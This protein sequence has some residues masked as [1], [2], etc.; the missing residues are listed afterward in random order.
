MC[1]FATLTMS[2]EM[3]F[4]KPKLVHLFAWLGS[5]IVPKNALIFFERKTVLQNKQVLRKKELPQFQ[6][7]IIETCKI[8]WF[9]NS[10]Q[11]DII[12]EMEDEFFPK[13]LSLMCNLT[14]NPHIY[15]LHGNSFCKRHIL[16]TIE[17]TNLF[18]KPN[19]TILLIQKLTHHH[20]VKKRVL[21]KW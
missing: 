11:F 7:L 20:G 3:K 19:I 17:F 12:A 6:V 1:G 18:S 5:C 9:C 10:C 13:S 8:F 15:I 21:Q 16:T 2:K 14:F 4:F